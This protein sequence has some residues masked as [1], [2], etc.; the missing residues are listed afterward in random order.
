MSRAVAYFDS[1]TQAA[2]SAEDI[3]TFVY[4]ADGSKEDRSQPR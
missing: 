4:N 2:R 3:T 1:R